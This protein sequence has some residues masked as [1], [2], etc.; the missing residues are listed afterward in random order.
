MPRK[1][2]TYETSSVRLKEDGVYRLSYGI[3][4]IAE[5]YGAVRL[6]ARVNGVRIPSAEA[7]GTVIKGALFPI[8]GE[9]I[10]RLSE[11]DSV[12]L[13]MKAKSSLLSSMRIASA[14][15]TVEQ[16]D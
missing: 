4:L 2:V 16:L 1:E 5:S 6:F 13:A 8:H 14:Y 3:V 11:G 10:V 12:D 9:A 15:L 7:T